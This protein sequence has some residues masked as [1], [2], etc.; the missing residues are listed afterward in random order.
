MD[1]ICYQMHMTIP[2]SRYESCYT[3][4]EKFEFLIFQ[5]RCGKCHISFVANF[6]CFPAEQKF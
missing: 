3:T 6:V 5:G 2:T 4:L 1:E